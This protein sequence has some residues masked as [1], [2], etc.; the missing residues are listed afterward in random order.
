MPPRAAVTRLECNEGGSSKFWQITV[1]GSTTDI[2]FGKIG[3]DGQTQTKD[4]GSPAAAQK[5]AD[6]QV[7]GKKKKGY[8][9]AG[10]RAPKAGAKAAAKAVAK[11]PAK[12]SAKASAKAPAKAAAKAKAGAKSKAAPRTAAKR[13]AGDEEDE[14]PAGKRARV[15]ADLGLPD[16][17]KLPMLWRLETGTDGFGVFVDSERCVMGNEDGL[18]A[19]V[20][21]KT[22]VPKTCYRL[23]AGVKCVVGDGD[24]LYV[25]TNKGSVYDLTSGNPRMVAE[26]RGF[27][28]LYWIDIYRGM[29]V[30]SDTKG[31]VGLLDCEGDVVWQKK[32]D[33]DSGWMVRIDATGIY[34]GTSKGVTKYDMQG[35][36]KWK[37]RDV[38]CVLFGVQTEDYVFAACDSVKAINDEPV[39]GMG[40]GGIIAKISKATGECELM[41]SCRNTTACCVSP[42]GKVAYDGNMGAMS[43]S[44]TGHAEFSEV[45]WRH[46]QSDTAMSMQ[47]FEDCVFLIEDS[48][49]CFDVSKKA[50]AAA[51]R[52]VF[53]KCTT[54]KWGEEN[55][56]SEVLADAQAV[57]E[58]TSA[59]GKIV[60]ECVKE[61]GK[62]R[63]RVISPGYNSSF[64]CQ[65]PKAIREASAKF[66]VDSVEL[67]GG[68]DF[69]RVRGDIQRFRG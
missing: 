39:D 42:D 9:P 28:E 10:G 40:P 41:M 23:P 46:V 69:Y 37:C 65:F 48:F 20:D 38:E 60:V 45:F 68:G 47:A 49:C 43:T 36:V 35:N 44:G 24:F 54:T 16:L 31:K 30:A 22:G 18:V 34:H 59:D 14:Q 64:N 27:G 52:G 26:I 25:G 3:T 19:D 58:A 63:V 29:I 12:A 50:I 53:P 6:K 4:H 1:N 33:G 15:S 2:T 7:E 8:T 67:A 57:Q 17:K 5:F 62:I 21:R 61:A 13:K 56:K 11:A 32:S 55:R 66:V 51:A